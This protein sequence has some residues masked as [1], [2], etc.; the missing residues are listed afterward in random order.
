M[1]D[2]IFNPINPSNDGF[3]LFQPV[4]LGEGESLYPEQYN[5]DVQATVEER[6]GQIIFQLNRAAQLLRALKFAQMSPLVGGIMDDIKGFRVFRDADEP[7]LGEAQYGDIW[8]QPDPENPAARVARIFNG[9]G[10]VEGLYAIDAILLPIKAR[11]QALESAQAESFGNLIDDLRAEL[12]GDATEDMD[13]FGEVEAAIAALASTVAG[14]R[15]AGDIPASDITGVLDPARIPPSVRA[16]PQVSS[17]GVADLTTEQQGNIGEGSPVLLSDGRVLYY[18]GTGSKTSEASYV[19]GADQTPAEAQIPALPISKI[20]GLQTALDGKQAALNGTN[21]QYLGF[22]GSGVPTAK[23][24][25]STEAGNL[26]RTVSSGALELLASDL[27][28]AGGSLR[29]YPNR[30]AATA[31]L[32]GNL[33]TGNIIVVG[34]GNG[35]FFEIAIGDFSS[36]LAADPAQGLIFPIGLADGSQAVARRIWEQ[37]QGISAAWFNIVPGTVNVT[38]WNQM[39][40]R[41]PG[42]Q[43]RTVWLRAGTYV[44]PSKPTFSEVV[45][46]WGAGLSLTY[47]ERG[48]SE[49]GGNEVGFFDFT[50]ELSRNSRLNHL[51]LRPA[52]GTTGGCMVKLATP[53]DVINSWCRW[54]HVLVTPFTGSY[55]VGIVVD[56][57]DNDVSGGQGHRDWVS[58]NCFVFPGSTGIAIRFYNATNG[59]HTGL[60]AGGDVVIDGGGTALQNTQDFAL[61]GLRCL[62]TVI[63][64]N[65]DRVFV[66]GVVNRV[67]IEATATRSFVNVTDRGGGVS[68]LAPASCQVITQNGSYGNFIYE[69]T[70]DFKSPPIFRDGFT[71]EKAASPHPTMPVNYRGTASQGGSIGG[72]QFNAFDN[73][74]PTPDFLTYV[75][76]RAVSRDITDG[77]EDGGFAID[78]RVNGSLITAW[79]FES[80]I[81]YQTATGDNR[82]AGTINCLDL[83]RNGVKVV[84]AR[85]TGFTA[86]TGTAEKG[87]LA[88]YAAGTASGTYVSSELQSVMTALQANSRRLKAIE[89]AL[90][91]HGLIGA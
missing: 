82:G 56:G 20:T 29:S 88:T 63:L 40:A 8:L 16:M 83:Y 90:F 33:N 75:V 43:T 51:T 34:G 64:R 14:K 23:P 48:Y 19:I 21:G 35:G 4:T 71:I 22:D 84:G 15:D 85:E 32:P 11:L 62:G 44:F 50:A 78:L 46:L 55:A 31:E 91:A 42:L 47:L 25:R 26:L 65:C 36:E 18:K 54:E 86:M 27:P 6:L 53:V 12:L 41:L 89:D 73:K 58:E 10:F 49:S 38:T 77:S 67:D 70:H 1:A 81:W 17:G 59:H 45:D 3:V 69:G 61:S 28:G 72:F 5:P 9:T 76:L 13:T 79:N 7:P 52:S 66:S 24:L 39:I 2:P 30:A 57:R 68:N 60:W 37:K 74:S 87:A 80:G